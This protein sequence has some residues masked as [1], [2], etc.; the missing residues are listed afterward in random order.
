MVEMVWWVIP[1]VYGKE[2][3][4]DMVSRWVWYVMVG[5]VRMGGKGGRGSAQTSLPRTQVI[6]RP[7][8]TFVNII[9][10]F[11]VFYFSFHD[12]CNIHN[13]SKLSFE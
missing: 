12:F 2:G 4:Y 8:S 6:P 3:K 13:P 7:S 10:R 1:T 11:S 5:M 9:L